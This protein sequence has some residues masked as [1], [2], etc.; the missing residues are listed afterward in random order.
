ML[1]ETDNAAAGGGARSCAARGLEEGKNLP[2]QNWGG[3]QGAIGDGHGHP[4]DSV[5]VE[6]VPPESQLPG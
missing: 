6:L 2:D 3:W 4:V 1:L 5:P